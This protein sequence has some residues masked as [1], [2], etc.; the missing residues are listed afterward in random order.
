MFS[1]KNEKIRP[2]NRQ[3]GKA[4]RFRDAVGR[5]V[6]YLKHTFPR[7]LK[8][9]GL[10]IV[11]DCAHGAGYK[12]APTVFQELGATAIP[13]YNKPDGSNINRKCGST[14]PEALQAAVR[15]HN[16]H[17]GI[18]VDG[19]ADRATS[20]KS[21]LATTRNGLRRLPLPSAA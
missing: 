4:F 9:D 8:L 1:R 12:V 21:A 11:V 6:V 18:A 16:A 10:K 15:K 20:N 5:Y 7:G 14:H 19:D 17:I 2:T 13:I 3:V